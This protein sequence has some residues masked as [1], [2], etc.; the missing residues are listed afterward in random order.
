MVSFP[1]LVNRGT[2]ILNRSLNRIFTLGQCQELYCFPVLS[3]LEGS[4][5]WPLPRCSCCRKDSSEAETQISFP[6]ETESGN[7]LD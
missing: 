3:G 4:Q 5:L 7:G 1:Q 6:K 2:E